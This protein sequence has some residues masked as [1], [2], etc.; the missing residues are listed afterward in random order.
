MTFP[1]YGSDRELASA[2]GAGGGSGSGGNGIVGGGSGG[3]G[4]GFGCGPGQES[5]L[6]GGIVRQIIYAT[7]SVTSM[8]SRVAREYG[9]SSCAPCI[10]IMACSRA[11]PGNVP[12]ISTARPNVPSSAR[13]I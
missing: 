8:L 5:G 12:I 7:D 11:R 2:C 6:V 10:S 3:A 9:Q 4:S 1:S 13:V